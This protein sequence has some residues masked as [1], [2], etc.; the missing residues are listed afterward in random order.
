[1]FAQTRRF[2]AR[3]VRG[4][5]RQALPM[6]RASWFAMALA[7]TV[8][9]LQVLTALNPALHGSLVRW[10]GLSG[11]GL[12]RLELYRLALSPLI[13]T[14][15]GFV[16]TVWV[17][18]LLAA[19]FAAWRIGPW[20]SA[21]IFFLSDWAGSLLVMATVGVAA[22]LGNSDAHQQ[23]FAQDVGSSSGVYALGFAAVLSL[24]GRL[25]TALVAGILAVFTFRLVAIGQVFDYE[26]AVSLMA[27]ALLLAL[28]ARPP[29]VPWPLRAKQRAAKARAAPAQVP[30]D[31]GAQRLPAPLPASDSLPLPAA[32]DARWRCASSGSACR[33]SEGAASREIEPGPAIPA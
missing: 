26:H 32:E 12:Q 20:R 11:P 29:A 33:D 15:P 2:V 13:Q 23:W 22:A 7:A 5:R 16:G 30:L 1:M 8:I 28:T 14:R 6:V 9:G 17:I 21:A 10:F 19:P 27:A 4:G 25:R 18:L 31:A 24:R 3:Q